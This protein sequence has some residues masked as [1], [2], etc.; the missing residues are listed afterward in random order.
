MPNFTAYKEKKSLISLY[1]I[2]R[3][4]PAPPATWKNTCQYQVSQSYSPDHFHISDNKKCQMKMWT[5]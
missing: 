1:F 5:S 3:R 2:F 4:L